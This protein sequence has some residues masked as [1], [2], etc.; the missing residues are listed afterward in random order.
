[1]RYREEACTICS[2][3]N[4]ESNVEHRVKLILDRFGDK[5][6]EAHIVRKDQFIQHVA[7][8]TK[9]MMFPDMK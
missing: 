6:P 8:K 4:F 9:K 2:S 1:M 7:V 3:L 5:F